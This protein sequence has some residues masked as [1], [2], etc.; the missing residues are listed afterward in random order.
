MKQSRFVGFT[1]VI[2]AQAW[3]IDAGDQAAA[4]V[5]AQLADAMKLDSADRE[6]RSYFP[7]RPVRVVS[8]NNDLPAPEALVHRLKNLSGEEALFCH[9]LELSAAIARD[10]Q[11]SGYVL[12]HGALA[13]YAGKGVILA[14]PGGTGKSTASNR[15]PH[16]WMSLCDDTTLVR[17]DANSQYWAHPWPTWSNFLYGGKGGAWNVQSAVP[18]EGIYYLKRALHDSVKP[19]GKGQALTNLNISAHQAGHV[20]ERGTSDTDKRALRL[21]RFNHLSALAGA[22]PMF[23]LSLSLTGEFWKEIEGVMITDEGSRRYAQSR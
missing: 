1:L 7:V 21:E 4:S 20:M 9:L 23:A 19:M 17:C 16:P 11:A 15:L 2:G 14:A 22:V 6:N 10:A 3:R 12:L 13:E 5:V 8:H 18:L